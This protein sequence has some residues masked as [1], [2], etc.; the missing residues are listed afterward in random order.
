M[1]D[2]IFFDTSLLAKFKDR[3]IKVRIRF[4]CTDDKLEQLM[5]QGMTKA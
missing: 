2:Y 3:L 4:E 1:L 5:E